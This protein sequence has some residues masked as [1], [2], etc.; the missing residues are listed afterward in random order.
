[1]IWAVTLEMI[2]YTYAQPC[3]QVSQLPLF[4]G[5]CMLRI[6]DGFESCR[7]RGSHNNDL[8]SPGQGDSLTDMTFLWWISHSRIAWFRISSWLRWWRQWRTT[9]RMT[10]MMMFVPP[11]MVWALRQQWP[12]QL[13]NEPCRCGTLQVVQI[14]IF[15]F[16]YIHTFLYIQG[17]GTECPLREVRC[18]YESNYIY[19]P[20]WAVLHNI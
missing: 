3:P 8:F 17:F 15:S 9:R 14:D 6:G 13:R 18:I 4:C 1:M 5:S 19:I 16:A 7:A 12:P 2:H 11:N 10:T 20:Y